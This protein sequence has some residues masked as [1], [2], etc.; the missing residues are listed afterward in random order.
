MSPTIEVAVHIA[1]ALIVLGLLAASVRLVLGPSRADRVVALDLIT[2]ML[3]AIAALLVP[4]AGRL[5]Y[6]DLSLALALIGFLATVA[7][8]RYV[9]HSPR[10]EPDEESGS[11]VP[12]GAARGAT[13]SDASG[14]PNDRSSGGG[15]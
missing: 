15:P 9:E 10:R 13:A 1:L 11:I 5:A 8:A 2:V 3:V 6:L 4:L 12:S 14:A 7:F